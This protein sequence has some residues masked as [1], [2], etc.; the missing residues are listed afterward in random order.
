MLVEFSV[1]VLVGVCF[2]A[3][4]CGDRVYMGDDDVLVGEY[5]VLFASLS[6]LYSLIFTKFFLVFHHAYSHISISFIFFFLGLG[7]V[8]LG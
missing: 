6:S 8:C 2:W 7:F 5:V 3:L 1:G 4:R